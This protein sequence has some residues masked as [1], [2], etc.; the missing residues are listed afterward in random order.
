MS[1][2]WYCC[3]CSHGPH[4]VG[5]QRACAQCG[6]ERCPDC[7]LDTQ[8]S[9]TSVHTCHEMSPYPSAPAPQG[10]EPSLNTVANMPSI[11]GYA[12]SLRQPSLSHRHV[13]I[14]HGMPGKDSRGIVGHASLYYCCQCGDGPKIY[15]HQP[16][17][18]LCQHVV[19][20]G[21]KPAK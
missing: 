4:Q 7:P 20:S 13:H 16:R 14:Q 6:E 2:L 5:L 21:C 12:Q 10:R 11:T 8:D 9:A 1:G 19:C 18:V 3:D 15:E 17:C